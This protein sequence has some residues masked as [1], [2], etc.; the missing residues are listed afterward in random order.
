M[1]SVLWVHNSG[2]QATSGHRP[3]NL[4]GSEKH[5]V[6]VS[7]TRHLLTPD[8]QHH[9]A[10]HYDT[11]HSTRPA[12]SRLTFALPRQCA[13]RSTMADAHYHPAPSSPEPTTPTPTPTPTP[14]QTR[15]PFALCAN[16]V[17]SA[18]LASVLA[19][20]WV[21]PLVSLGARRPL[22]RQDLWPIAPEDT[23]DAVHDRFAREYTPLQP[24]AQTSSLLP[25][26]FIAI[27][28]TFR[29]NVMVIFANFI[30]CILA[31]ALQAF[32]AQ[33][34]LD[35]L[36]VLNTAM[37]FLTP[38]LL[39]GATLG[40]YI[41]IEGSVSVTDAFTLIAMVNVCRVAVGMFP[42]A[43]AAASQARTAVRRIDGF[44][45]GEELDK[46][47]TGTP[48]TDEACSGR[49][50]ITDG[51]FHWSRSQIALD[52]VVVAAADLEPSRVDSPAPDPARADG[53]FC[54]DE[55]NVDIA[56]G[57]LV[58]IV[59]EVGAGKTS[60]LNAI[61]GEM[62]IE[63]GTVTVHGD[64]TYVAQEA[65]IRNSSVKDNILF[66]D[67]LDATRYEQ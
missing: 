8:T 19:A 50:T 55:V 57:T 52:G 14:T 13:L 34:T 9:C 62:A 35:F 65:W 16:P 54:L 53:R 7:T 26:L 25:P 33:A 46:S 21:Q 37:L 56:A 31:L 67:P 30:V 61:L 28:R 49:I 39:S 51:R 60:L 10:R 66:E 23:C 32:A 42:R 15:T 47:S 22:E 38:T 27:L 44:L 11:R 6:D 29:L 18:S 2:D 36:Q 63:H 40:A 41:L 48:S 59:G 12:A 64:V 24:G 4:F 43:I 45:A 1:D 5:L 20:H 3:E 17:S 58:M